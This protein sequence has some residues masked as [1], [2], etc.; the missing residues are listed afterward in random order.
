[1]FDE[2]RWGMSCR[3]V[4]HELNVNESI[5]FINQGAFKQK[6]TQQGDELVNML[7]RCV[8]PGTT[9]QQSVF[10]VAYGAR[11][12]CLTRSAHSRLSLVPGL[13]SSHESY[14]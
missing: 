9:A 5:V 10:T 12:L 6:H 1:M 2:L 4:G 8:S 13:L 11:L 3:A 14:S 7:R